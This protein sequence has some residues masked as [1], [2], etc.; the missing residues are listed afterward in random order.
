MKKAI[1][2]RRILLAAL[3]LLCC[4]M[5]AFVLVACNKKT[6]PPP[7]SGDEAGEYYYD[8]A[9]TAERYRLVLGGELE[10]TFVAGSTVEQGSYTLE[11]NAI[12]LTGSDDW[13]LSGT[14]QD[15]AISFTYEDSPVRFIRMTYYTVSFDTAGGS[16]VASVQ[17]LNGKAVAKP[18]A[19]PTY[20]GH[21]FLGWYAD[22]EHKTPYNFEGMQ[23]VSSNMTI[24]A[25]WAAVSEGKEYTVS[26][27]TGD[28]QVLPDDE[29]IGG[30]LYNA[31]VP[32]AREGYDFVGWWISMENRADR[33]TCR[34]EEP[35]GDDDGTVFDA[36]TTLFAVWQAQSAATDAPAVSVNAQSISWDSV[37]AARY[38]LTVTAPDGTVVENS[39]P[40]AT[41]VAAGEI[42]TETGTYRIDVTALNE[43]GTAIS[44][45]TVRYF[46]NNALK[47]VSGV[48]VLDPD[49]LVYEAVE[50]AESYIITVDCG[51]PR[52]E[53]D[54]YDNGT[55]L[56]FDFSNCAMQPGGIVFTISATAEG[57]A[58]SSTTFVYERSLAAVT[59]AEVADDVLLWDAVKGAT[60]YKVEIGKDVFY[61][62]Q[63]EFSLKTIAS[64]D[65]S[66]S[67]TAMADGFNPSEAAKLSYKKATPALPSS[68]KLTGTV[69]SWSA[70]AEAVSYQLVVDGKTVDIPEGQ[71]SY[72]L[73]DIA[74]T[75]GSEYSIQLKTVKGGVSSLSET[76]SFVYRALEPTLTYEN[77]VLRWKAVAGADSYEIRV[78]ETVYTV[79]D[80]SNFL[81]LDTLAN[82]GRNTVT[83]TFSSELG[84][85]DPATLN[86]YAQA[87]TFI[88]G[89]NN[90]TSV[91]YYKAA[92]DELVPPAA[93]AI[94]GKDFAAWYNTPNGP[95]GF[96]AA[97]DDPFFFGPGELVL[98]AY[99]EAKAVT[100]SLSGADG[101]TSA[102]V[103]YGEDFT[104]P[105]PESTDGARAF[106]G[107]FSA[108][109]GAGEA[110]T[111]AH[112]NSLRVWE[113]LDEV[114]LYAFW[115]DGVLSYS[116]IPG[117]YIV[118]RGARINLVDTV[119]VP[120]SYNGAP[121]IEVA[122]SGFKDCAN[123]KE[124][125]LPDT[126]TR[127]PTDSAFSGCTALININVYDTGAA[128][129]RYSSEGGVLY[130]SGAAGSTHAIRPA[131]MPAAKTGSYTIPDGVDV[132]PSSAF[133]G[134]AIEKIVIPASVTAI[135]REA[136]ADCANLVS[137]V[138]ENLGANGPALTVGARAFANC[139]SLAEITFPARLA[140]ITL[141]RY[142]S[143]RVD[144][145]E[146]IDELVEFAEDAFIGCELLESINVATNSSAKYTSADG[147]LYSD[148][149]R[150]LVYFP[151]AKDATGYTIPSNVLTIADGAFFGTGLTGNLTL[152]ANTTS[153][154]A[155]AFADTPIVGLT[156]A[157]G[158]LSNV[159]LGDYA[160]Y[161]CR[162]LT[163]L[164]FE[165]NSKITNIGASAFANCTSL[166]SIALPATLETVGSSAF[167]SCGTA[168]GY[169]YLNV[170]F[171]AAEG[172]TLTFG[173]AVFADCTIQKLSIPSHA[174]IDVSF[175]EGLTV[176]EFEAEGNESVA[177]VQH[178][179][180]DGSTVLGSALYLKAQDGSL[181]TLLRYIGTGYGYKTFEFKDENGEVIP[182]KAISPNAFEGINKIGKVVIP[183]SVESIGN[184]AFYESG[185]DTVTF[186]AGGDKAL[187]IGEYAFSGLEIGDLALPARAVTIGDY[188][189]SELKYL[190]TLDLG[191]TTS[192][193]AY[194]FDAAGYNTE[195]TVTIPASVETIGDYAFHGGWYYGATALTFAENSALKSIGSYA[196]SETRIESVTIPA[197]VQTIGDQ[198]FADSEDLSSVN[199]EEGAVPL[200]F[201]TGKA[202]GT[203]TDAR[204]G[205]VLDGTA[206]TALHFPGRLTAVGDYALYGMDE[207]TELT[208]GDQYAP[209]QGE[210]AFTKSKL[211][212]IGA[213]AFA[214][215]GNF[216]IEDDVYVYYGLPEITIPASIQNT[217]D[218]IAIGAYAFYGDYNLQTVVFEANGTNGVTIGESAFLGCRKLTSVTLPAT[219]APFTAADGTT[220]PALANGSGVFYQT[221]GS[222]GLQEI[223]VAE[224]GT[225][226]ASKDGV[227]YTA[228]FGELILCPA[229]K[230]G[231]VEIDKRTVRIADRAFASSG[232]FTGITAITFEEGSALEEIG[233]E[234]FRG[235]AL[236]K[237]IV[238]PDSVKTIGENVFGNCRALTEVTLSASL[239]AF[240]EGMIGTDSVTR[241]FVSEKS[242][243]LKSEGGRVL[244]SQDGKSLL[245]Y[246]A[247]NT[248]TSYTIAEGAVTIA[249]NAFANNSR[250]EEIVIPGSV[251][252]IAAGAFRNTYNLAT[253]TFKDGTAPLTIGDEAF[254]ESDIT[255]LKLPERTMA[256]GDAAFRNA[257]LETIDFGTNSNINT[258]GDNVFSGTEL[259]TVTLPA[260]IRTM[261]DGVFSGCT[262][263][264]S[265]VLPEGLTEMGSNTFACGEEGDF[266]SAAEAEE[267]I[268]DEDSY[269][270]Y[271][272]YSKLVSVTFPASLTKIGSGTF[273]NN[274]RLESVTFKAGAKVE[275]LAADTFRGCFRLE[276]IVLPAALT[277]IAGATEDNDGLFEG[278]SSLASVTFEEGS[279]CLTIGESAFA[280]TAL[281]KFDIPASVQT[282]GRMAFMGSKLTSI[283]I[284]RTVTSIGAYAFNGCALESVT[285][286]DGIT[287]IPASAFTNNAA[288]ERINIPASVTA[289]DATAFSGCTNLEITLDSGNTAFKKDANGVLFNAAQTQI[290]FIPVSIETFTVPATLTSTD[291][292]ALLENIDTLSSIAVADGNTAFC[293]AFGALYSADW[294]L[295]FVPN[296]MTSFTIPAEVSM[297]PVYGYQEGTRVFGGK[298]IESIT[299]DKAAQRTK[300]LTIRDGM[301]GTAVF[302][303]LSS[304]ESVEL[305]ANTSVG[306]YAFSY[307]SN[308]ETL[309]LTAGTSGTIG[310]YAFRSCSSLQT[311]V[312]PEGYT[313][314]GECAFRACSALTSVSLPASLTSLSEDT[315]QDCDSVS[316]TVAEGNK[317]FAIVNEVLFNSDKTAIYYIPSDITTFTVPAAY[318]GDLTETLAYIETLATITVES[319]NT[320]YQSHDGVLYDTDWNI[321]VLPMA[322][323][324]Y[325]IPKEV[326]AI[327]AQGYFNYSNIETIDFEEGRTQPLKLGNAHMG[328]PDY[329]VFANMPALTSVKLPANTTIGTYAFAQDAN[330]TTVTLTAGTSGTI[331]NYVFQDTES[332]ASLTVP[333][334][335]TSI[336]SYAFRR[337]GINSISLPATLNS[338]QDTTFSDCT[339]LSSIT[340]AD[341]NETF[342][343]DSNGSLLGADGKVYFLLSTFTIAADNTDTSLV[344]TL[345]GF[346]TLE[347]IVVEDGNTAYRSS[348]GALYD[349][350]WNLL[351][352][353]KAKTTFVIP[354]QVTNLSMADDGSNLFASSKIE[355]I[356]FEDGRE[357]PLTI[358]DGLNQ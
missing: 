244:Y 52:H 89:E 221:N 317:S 354:K 304:L 218:A 143:A 140:D 17:I 147:V 357:D 41:T 260:S 285:L 10:F 196:F 267:A 114:T 311:V 159:T 268:A 272:S 202:Q 344:A 256:I 331:G 358:G 167:A 316:I 243:F 58:P 271:E 255:A 348:N 281:T 261:G 158:G 14:M 301:N 75:D 80:G 172:K 263:L 163:S 279:K 258:L 38:K 219:L 251:E 190:E 86:V 28:G 152:H 351:V 79:S 127:I 78:G 135:E 355:T 222:T 91:T 177:T 50:N 37:G 113:R 40:T 229:A 138:F 232:E 274:I 48:Q 30:K 297:L 204:I 44:E 83:V 117:G 318:T 337:S 214:N 27:D 336:G 253:V 210:A 150:T 5:I 335:Y 276:E 95:D 275:T 294:E 109:N 53:H 126:L 231:T 170:T 323:T 266:E 65:L 298:N 22:A 186:T 200:T 236:I 208:F 238:L 188:A 132:I 320:A 66:L 110:Y 72:D 162:S 165:E 349:S 270:S 137:V 341:G 259:T 99:Y 23:P 68:I 51:D 1:R 106:G 70:A 292:I 228:D 225:E 213:Y 313:S 347:E 146:T 16:S 295:L 108:P 289:I 92:G 302:N 220:I 350:E 148:N 88:S 81:K 36:D 343:V 282:I 15:G 288:L 145:F 129:A 101:M 338:L 12:T 322:K 6:P 124:I 209:E 211:T 340:V 183:A 32:A 133:A 156:F 199:F 319:G 332:L 325:T 308:L 74:W 116:S 102:I 71:T 87:V 207:I 352:I 33:L 309:T 174:V 125:N 356:T 77:G 303:S 246:L 121:V 31:P 175:L 326:T 283:E 63:T 46:V 173:A 182:V 195:L 237:S 180:T 247:S 169:G 76:F 178:L 94:T 265:V 329:G 184:Y 168:V 314:V 254:S 345:R 239:E 60:Y 286:S 257:S 353:P 346:E 130:D 11:E 248:E 149:G 134:S 315:F 155:F 21:V 24:Y 128:G 69:L 321:V 164:L 84:R 242:A 39:T 306:S 4:A 151:A 61:T 327:S 120:A 13:S 55:A 115:V 262:S 212:T 112:G 131:F 284:P 215:M 194:A 25:R 291:F 299:Y 328:M 187:S 176:S 57:Y 287:E 334:G 185:V 64:G 252:N 290:V 111:D 235:Q 224:G 34:F 241:I 234:A 8:D 193:G 85:S 93:A 142:D 122:A 226:Y 42:F 29:T 161:G 230:Q 136:F 45:T 160:F 216:K 104:L 47:R 123:L 153:V 107:W 59:G 157:G 278:L 49:V 20:G 273:L 154:G 198:A 307:C 269:D 312:I 191:G 171:A 67:V 9:D 18:D 305:P 333:E 300:G 293:A 233:D 7:Q 54:A 166:A 206:V 98:Y 205:R 141:Q 330:L 240:D 249:E 201:G 139:T 144:S 192:V 19:D 223:N 280:G 56:Y 3:A 118:S 217:A 2:N 296:A 250:L 245:Y 90:T 103:Y 264:T 179:D 203:D 342:H 339:A 62:T 35:M 277:E 197:S 96:G 73:T 82:A 181:S 119:T 43:G 100:V 310:N 97:F 189:F 324:S 227:L 26:Y 105:V